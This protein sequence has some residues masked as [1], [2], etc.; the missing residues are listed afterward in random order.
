MS[1]M[2]FSGFLFTLFQHISLDLLSLGSA[3]A[4][5]EW[6]GKLNGHLM[7]GYVRNIRTKN[8]QNLIIGFQVTAKNVGD[9]FLGHSDIEFNTYSSWRLFNKNTE[10]RYFCHSYS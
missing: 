5:I 2:F 9:V 7:S 6:G 1:G 4:Y 8:Y 10:Y 3:K